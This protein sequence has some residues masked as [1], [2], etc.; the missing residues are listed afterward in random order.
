MKI[1]IVIGHNAIGGAEKQARTLFR[2]LGKLGHDIDLMFLRNAVF[3]QG[4]KSEESQELFKQMNFPSNKINPRY[5][6]QF[7]RLLFDLK[8]EKYD[9][10]HSFLPESVVLISL[11]KKLS[12]DRALHVAGVR[13]EF[14]ENIGIR[15]KLY[16][17]LLRKC[18]WIICNT[19]S[20]KNTCVFEY[21]INPI[22]ISIIQNGVEK[23]DIKRK[24]INKPIKSVVVSNYH[25][26]KGFDL[27]FDALTRIKNQ[28]ELYVVGR[29]EF[30]DV[31]EPYR[32][33]IPPNVKIT[34]L[35]EI[36]SFSLYQDFDFA[37]HPSTTEGMSNAIME[38]LANGL[39]VIAFN[40]GGNSELI[41]DGYNGILIEDLDSHQLSEKINLLLRN[42]KLI[43]QMSVNAAPSMD[44]FSFE[45]L[46]IRHIECYRQ[47][48]MDK[49]L[50]F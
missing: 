43:T 14:F 39:P 13:G 31:I 25:K 36:K 34:F 47:I 1:L 50:S 6:V 15:E 9:I 30:K 26:Y 7:I 24:V 19:R 3:G 4:L 8:R 45:N 2:L 17:N 42:P 44:S 22:K 12:R 27:L 46:S 5:V 11:Y 28:F 37:I 10:I 18:D 21:R 16:M 32:Q 20:L 38:E 49:E 33:E 41:Q 48:I 23:K 40:V 35:G 29:G